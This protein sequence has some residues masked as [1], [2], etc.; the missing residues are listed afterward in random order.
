MR[1][2]CN[3]LILSIIVFF[4]FLTLGA[5]YALA[6]GDAYFPQD[7]TVQLTVDGTT[8]DFTIIGGSDANEVTT[9][10]SSVTVSISSGQTFTFK[11]STGNKLTNN[12]GFAYSCSGNESTLTLTV[13][14]QQ[15][16][17]ISPDEPGCAS[18]GG[19]GGGAG[20]VSGSVAS[21]P[22]PVSSPTAMGATPVSRGFVS[23]AALSLK[24]GDVVSAAGS[25][26]PD[27]YIVNSW[28]YKRLFLNPVIFGFYG[29]LGGFSKVKNA[30]VSTRDTL[31]TSGLFRNCETND[32]KVYGVEV[33]GEDTGALHWVN[34]T[35]AQAVAD[36]PEFFKKV[37]CINNNE[38]N[39]YKKGTA[40]SSVKDIPSYSRKGAVLSS[41]V[42]VIVATTGKLK[43]V[44]SVA[45]LNVRSTNSTSGQ[46]IT[47]VLPNQEFAFVDYKNDW[48]KIQ[49]DGKDFGW[50]FGKYVVK[51]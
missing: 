43:V 16:I 46:I 21:T 10:A 13:S 8:T 17:V 9:D 34:T 47:K 45:W 6:V 30:V 2:K 27:V 40:Y 49:K 3:L 4:T 50:V 28:G 25:D 38:F 39:W 18:G 1:K 33:T 12:G 11:S 35:G 22:I 36:D 19:G 37:F 31:V 14:S 29:H 15:T 44:D 51:L 7:T 24:E 23:L 41:P 26:D 20:G 32:P 5:G 48:Y 42:S